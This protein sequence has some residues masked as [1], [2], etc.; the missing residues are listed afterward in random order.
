MPYELCG[1]VFI[2]TNSGLHLTPTVSIYPDDV[3][4]ELSGHEV[5]IPR[6]S[7]NGITVN[8]TYNVKMDDST[9]NGGIVFVC[10]VNVR[11]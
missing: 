7:D 11:R 4:M 2:V 6:T 5:Y 1:S 9:A 8:F 3:S 10:G